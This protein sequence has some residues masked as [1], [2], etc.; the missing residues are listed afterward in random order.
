M[1]K[2]LVLSGL[3]IL[4]VILAGLTYYFYPYVLYRTSNSTPAPAEPIKEPN[5]LLNLSG[6]Q[7]YL[8]SL[9][10]SK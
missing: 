1:N 5:Q 3:T 9:D 7:D 10:R 8:N 2:K 4:V 6:Y